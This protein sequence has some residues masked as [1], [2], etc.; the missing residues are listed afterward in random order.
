MII[1]SYFPLG[2]SFAPEL[3]IEVVSVSD[4]ALDVEKKVDLYLSYGTRLVWVINP[5]LKSASIHRANRS[6]QRIRVDDALDG[7]DVLPSFKC[8]L[9]DIL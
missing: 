2:H 3:R 7:E 4:S 1:R 6:L 9:T 5:R 8:V